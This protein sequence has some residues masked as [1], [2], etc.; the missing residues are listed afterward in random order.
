MPMYVSKKE[1]A[2]QKLPVTKVVGLCFKHTKEMC[3]QSQGF[4]QKTPFGKIPVRDEVYALRAE[5]K[6]VKTPYSAR[7]EEKTYRSAAPGERPF[8]RVPMWW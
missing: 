3:D 4:W 7:D 1:G 6:A 8:L 5:S 2:P